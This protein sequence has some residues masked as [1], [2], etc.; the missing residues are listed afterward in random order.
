[1]TYKVK[2]VLSTKQIPKKDGSGTF[3]KNQVLTEDD[4]V[5]DVIGEVKEGESLEGEVIDDPKWGKQFKRAGFV[6]GKFGS[7][8]DPEINRMIIRQNALTNAVNYAIAK[9]AKTPDKM[10]GKEIIQCATYFAKYSEGK[11]TVVMTPEEIAK[12][13]GYEEPKSHPELDMNEPNEENSDESE[14]RPE[15]IPF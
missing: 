7:K 9:Y 3:S 12:E 14:V 6:G 2:K 8:N 11:V 1:M 4:L 5:F 15:D 10:S 13:F